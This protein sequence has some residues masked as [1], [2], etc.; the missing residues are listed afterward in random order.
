MTHSGP[1]LFNRQLVAIG[2]TLDG[3]QRTTGIPIRGHIDLRKYRLADISISVDVDLRTYRFEGRQICGHAA[4]VSCS[5]AKESA[6]L[7]R[8]GD[9]ACSAILGISN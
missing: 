9:Q 5:T 4:S 7:A 1:Q 2:I 3:A 6:G 8:A